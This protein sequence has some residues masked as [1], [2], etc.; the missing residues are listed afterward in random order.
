MRID[1]LG[2]DGGLVIAISA[3][4]QVGPRGVRIVDL[5]SGMKRPQSGIGGLIVGHGSH[6]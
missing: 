5:L 2:I 3:D 6:G 4:T 1:V